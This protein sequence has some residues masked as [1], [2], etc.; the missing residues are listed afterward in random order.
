[1]KVTMEEVYMLR[2]SEKAEQKKMDPNFGDQN[3]IG[4]K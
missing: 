4:Q 3:T 1:M 2:K